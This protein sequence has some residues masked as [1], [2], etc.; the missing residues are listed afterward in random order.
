MKT[1]AEQII[2]LVDL[3]PD[4]KDSSNSEA[5]KNDP[6]IK[7]TVLW[8]DPKGLEEVDCKYDEIPSSFK[9]RIPDSGTISSIM[10]D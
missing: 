4:L 5:V 7:Y 10:Y 1:D 9:F 6:K 8:D 3:W 2:T